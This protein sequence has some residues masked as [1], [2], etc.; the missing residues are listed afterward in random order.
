M[1][2]GLGSVDGGAK[3][4][5]FSASSKRRIKNDLTPVAKTSN[6]DGVK[7]LKGTR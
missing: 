4:L 7:S 2:F 1:F 6:R 3:A 5:K